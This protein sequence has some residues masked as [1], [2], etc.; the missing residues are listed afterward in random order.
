VIFESR[1]PSRLSRSN[2]GA[3]RVVEAV[4]QAM[5][6]TGQS[7]KESTALVLRRG[8]YIIAAGLD[9]ASNNAPVTLKGR[10]IPLFDAAQSVVNNYTV[11]PGSRGLLVDLD[12]YPKDFTGVIAA[13]CHVSNE[14]VTDE[15]IALD[16]IGQDGTNAVVSVLMPR[17]PKRVLNDGEALAPAA[18]DYSN[19]VLRMRFPN[20]ARTLHITIAR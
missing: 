18:F 11:A 5:N 13:A 2:D 9:A 16:T 6:S 10:F 20:R 15:S 7:W 4:K 8:P 1:S 3:E 17:A 12:R 19:G 14:A